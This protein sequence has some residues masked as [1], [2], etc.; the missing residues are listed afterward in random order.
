MIIYR[1]VSFTFRTLSPGISEYLQSFC[2]RSVRKK[3]KKDL[4]AKWENSCVFWRRIGWFLRAFP[5][6]L[7]S[8]YDQIPFFTAP[9]ALGV[10]FIFIL[11]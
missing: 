1:N 10:Y 6:L 11:R 5:V 3:G 9:I 4:M 2:K 7:I 8:S